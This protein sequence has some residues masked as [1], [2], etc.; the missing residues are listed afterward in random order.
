MVEGVPKVDL[1]ICQTVL[2][3]D[4]ITGSTLDGNE[5]LQVNMAVP[6]S[7]LVKPDKLH[8]V[9]YAEKLWPIVWLDKHVRQ[10]ECDAIFE[11]INGLCAAYTKLT[12]HNFSLVHHRPK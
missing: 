8:N 1:S 9:T 4:P 7:L 3:V 2:H 11:S 10:C 12:F 5:R 6:A